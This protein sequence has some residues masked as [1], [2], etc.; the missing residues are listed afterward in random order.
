MRPCY[1]ER[2]PEKHKTAMIKFLSDTLT[3]HMVII[4]SQLEKN[5]GFLVGKEVR[6]DNK[7]LTVMR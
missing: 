4:E 6:G 7:V 3:P 1:G 2:D 5:G